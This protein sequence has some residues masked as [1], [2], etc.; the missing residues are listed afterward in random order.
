VGVVVG[1]PRRTV[2]LARQGPT[3]DHHKGEEPRLTGGAAR[4]ELGGERLVIA[5]RVAQQSREAGQRAAELR[6]Q[7]QG[8]MSGQSHGVGR[9]PCGQ[10][11]VLLTCSMEGV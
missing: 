11:Y 9:G 2:G 3:A 8:Q 1:C 7:F 10:I 5:S 6:A 4:Q